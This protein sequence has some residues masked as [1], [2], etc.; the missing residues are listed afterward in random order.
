[1]VQNRDIIVLMQS[2]A[3]INFIPKSAL[4][5]EQAASIMAHGASAA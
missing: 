3:A 2:E 1:L 4:S 5:D